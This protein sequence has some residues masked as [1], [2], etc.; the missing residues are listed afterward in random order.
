VD[1]SSRGGAPLDPLVGRNVLLG[2]T[3]GVVAWCGY[4]VAYLLPIVGSPDAHAHFAFNTAPSW[5][6]IGAI[7]TV[8]SLQ[9]MMGLLFILLLVGVRRS[10]KANWL[11]TAL[12]MLVLFTFDS[13]RVVN[14]DPDASSWSIPARRALAWSWS[15]AVCATLVTLYARVG[16]LAAVAFVVTENTAQLIPALADWTAWHAWNAVAPA[17]FIMLLALWGAGATSFGR[18]ANDA[19]LDAGSSSRLRPR[20]A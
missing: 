6:N 14:I 2:A 5:V 13:S 4:R 19:L 1:A 7:A 12:M 20:S 15:L 18:P 11:A 17:A 10:V 3:L 16:V 8:V 9:S